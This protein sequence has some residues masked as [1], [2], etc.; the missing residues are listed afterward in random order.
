MKVCEGIIIKYME[1]SF[2]W[3]EGIHYTPEIYL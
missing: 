1:M 2:S 3:K